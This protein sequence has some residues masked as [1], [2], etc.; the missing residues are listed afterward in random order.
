MLWCELF[1]YNRICYYIKLATD[2]AQLWHFF[3]LTIAITIVGTLF[4]ECCNASWIIFVYDEFLS[5]LR[6]GRSFKE[7]LKNQL[8]E[9]LQKDQN[10]L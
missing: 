2:P 1:V 5:P 10:D 6:L 4:A 7:E 8:V 9:W 3:W